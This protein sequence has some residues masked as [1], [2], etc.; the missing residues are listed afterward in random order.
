M[1]MP[2]IGNL[3]KSRSETLSKKEIVIIITP[4]IVTGNVD[5]LDQPMA[6]KGSSTG[7]IRAASFHESTVDMFSPRAFDKEKSTGASPALNMAEAIATKES[8]HA[9]IGDAAEMVSNMAP[10]KKGK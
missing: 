1:D 3:F 2:V 9:L 5:V 10:A 7:N 6:L 4:H 8:S